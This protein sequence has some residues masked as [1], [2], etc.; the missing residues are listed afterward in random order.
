MPEKR[1]V[2]RDHQI[3]V[4]G[5]VEVPAIAVALGFDDAD[6]A[7]LLKRAVS[8]ARLGVEVGD[9]GQITV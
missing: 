7:K 6:L 1:I 2:R 9:G 8:G 3:G 4:A 5:L